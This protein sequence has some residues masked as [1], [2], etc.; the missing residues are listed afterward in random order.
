M[1]K[2]VAFTIALGVALSMAQAQTGG[3]HKGGR[4]GGK[5]GGKGGDRFEAMI[6]KLNLTEEQQAKLKPIMEAN[7]LKTES[8][9][10][11]ASLSVDQKKAKMR[12]NREAFE[13]EIKAI[14][15]PEQQQQLG[16]KKHHKPGPGK[17]QAPQQ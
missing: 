2:I 17:G 11:E 4:A 7:R 15:T 1:K 14:L 12:E 10:N 5:G 3:G 9:R 13:N 8:I 16:E 6:S